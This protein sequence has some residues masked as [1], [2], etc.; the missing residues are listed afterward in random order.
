MRISKIEIQ[1]FKAFWQTQPFDIENKNVLVFGTNGSGKSS[2][3]YSLHAFVQSSEKPDTERQKYFVF[4]GD[5]SLLN[6]HAPENFPS[7]IKVTVNNGVTYEFAHTPTDGCTLNT[8]DVVKLANKSSDF[9]NYRFMLAFSSFRNSQKADIFSIIRNEFFPFWENEAGVNYQTWYDSLLNEITQ[10]R[11][12][13][14]S[15]SKFQKRRFWRG[16]FQTYKDQLARFNTELE[17]KFLSYVETINDLMRD[18]FLKGDKIKLYH[19]PESFKGLQI[20]INSTWELREPEL[21]LRITKDDKTIPK[22]HVFLN[23][24]RLTGIALAMRMAIFDQR[25]RGAGDFKVLV[26]DDLL[27]SLDMGKRMEVINFVLTNDKFTNYQLFIFTHDKGFYNVLRNNLIKSDGDWKCFEFYENS[28]PTQYK[29]PL[30]IENLDSLKKAEKLLTGDPEANPPVPPKYDE[31]ALYLRKKAEELIRMFYD[32]GLENLSRFEVLE[33]LANSLGGFEK[34]FNGRIRSAFTSM[35]DDDNLLTEEIVN[36]LSSDPYINRALPREEIIKTNGLKFKI[37]RVVS[38]FQ[39]H[40]TAIK[41]HRENLVNRCKE[42]DE[43]RDRILN[44]GA[45][46]TGEP[47]FAGEL[48]VAVETMEQLQQRVRDS[49]QWFKDFELN[50]MKKDQQGS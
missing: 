11:S 27:L 26:L 39:K 25:Y 40:R 2:L 29:N 12:Q 32:P 22:P 16:A 43:L 30:V 18:Y 45:H 47:L 6:I 34:E 20:S 21:I 37:F 5:E 31:C 44:H 50:V 41:T 35:L 48:A 33:K 1:N 14:E 13:Y 28:N 9:M 42:V 7:F 17:T 19:N 15:S 49:L 4:D 36:R 23:E 24:A 46:P 8:D 10:L 38:E 3:F